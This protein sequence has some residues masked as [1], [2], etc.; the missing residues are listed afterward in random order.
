[1]NDPDRDNPETLQSS[2]DAGARHRSKMQNVQALRGNPLRRLLLRTYIR[3]LK[4]RGSPREIALGFA[5]GLFVAVSPTMGVQM[6]MAIFLAA[7]F[8]WSKLAAAIAVWVTNPLSA[9]F[10]YGLTYFIGARLMG[11]HTLRNLMGEPNLNALI[12]AVKKAP[13]ILAAMTLGGIIIGIPL[14]I[15]GYYLAYTAVVQ[16]Q[17]RL[18]DKIAVQKARMRHNKE[19]LKEKM[20]EQAERLRQKRENRKKKRAQRKKAERKKRRG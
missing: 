18:K 1:M 4:L 11:L 5:L 10:I 12:E 14:A 7:L 13:E 19:I 2:S 17:Q 3:F 20:H 15:V 16:Y 6:A 9:P 8:K